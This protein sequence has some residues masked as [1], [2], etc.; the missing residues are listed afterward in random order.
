MPEA[1]VVPA[2]LNIQ[3]RG[4]EEGPAWIERGPLAV[5]SDRVD[6]VD[7]KR[8]R[9][10][11]PLPALD[12]RGI[13]ST[14]RDLSGAPKVAA[15]VALA[16]LAVVTDLE[17][18]NLIAAGELVI[19]L[20]YHRTSGGGALTV[21]KDGERRGFEGESAMLG[22]LAIGRELGDEIVDGDLHR[23]AGDIERLYDRV[24]Q[25][26]SAGEYSFADVDLALLADSL[27]PEEA[28]TWEAEF[29]EIEAR[30]A[31]QR[32]LAE[33]IVAA[34]DAAPADA[35][36]IDLP[37]FAAA[38]RLR[39]PAFVVCPRP[40]LEVSGPPIEVPAA[41]RWRVDA[42]TPWIPEARLARF[43]AAIGRLQAAQIRARRQAL[44]SVGLLVVL[45][46]A[47]LYVALS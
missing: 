42:V 44:A 47:L 6:L 24:L 35:D 12:R 22:A 16:R 30:A 45:V 33:A 32:A 5:H 36:V 27:R 25:A 38:Q 21:V 41:E 20:D 7:W 17:A 3:P 28:A 23:I 9:S 2:L 10:F 31:D 37:G 46:A 11:A 40:G 34:L 19:T 4:S 8:R 39:E 29:A 18:D 13:T 43:T 15:R 1:I 14:T 26:L